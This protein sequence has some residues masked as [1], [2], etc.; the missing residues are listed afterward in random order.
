MDKITASLTTMYER[1]ESLKDTVNSLLSQVDKLNVYLHGYE[2]IPDFLKDEKIEVAYD[3]LEGDNGD[4]DKTY[5][6]D[7]VEGYHLVCDDDLI[8]PNDYADK[9]I[10]AV[11]RFNRKA[12]ISF[13][14][15]IIKEPPIN[16]YY[17]DR[18]SLPYSYGQIDDFLID[19]PGTGGLAYHSS[20]GFGNTDFRVKERNMLDIHTGIWAAE[21]K[22]PIYCLKHTAKWITHTE[23]IDLKETIFAKTFYNDGIPTK[24]INR[25]SGLFGK[26]YNRHI[27]LS[28]K[29]ESNG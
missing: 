27:S 21:N 22:L 8:Y 19:M 18:I 26:L 24:V 13:Y 11:E 9:M 16:S 5:W 2:I 28:K 15:S 14:G 3:F 25:T 23:K 20:V 4:L 29:V 1:Q 17:R 10:E 12:L 7:R 6:A